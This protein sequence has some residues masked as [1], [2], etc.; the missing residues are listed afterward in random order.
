MNF[1]KHHFKFLIMIILMI[2]FSDSKAQMFWNQTCQF[3]GTNTS[4][5]SLPSTSGTDITGSFTAE[6]WVNCSN[7]SGSERGIISKGSALGVS[8]RYA[9]RINNIGR[10]TV[11][12]NGVLR[13]TSATSVTV[14]TWTHIAA[15]YSSLNDSFAVYINGVKNIATV[16]GGATP[17]TNTDSLYIGI[18]GSGINYIGQLDDVRLWNRSLYPGEIAQNF[19][20]TLGTSGGMYGNLVFSLPFQK[21]HSG[22]TTFSTVDWTGNGNNG[23]GRNVTAV[24]QTGTQYTTISPNESLN[25]LGV[26]EYAA[27]PSNSLVSPSSQITLEAWIYPKS[28]LNNPTIIS[29]NSTTSY[30]LNLNTTGKVEFYPK[31][32]LSLITSKAIIFQNRWTHIAA[33]YNGSITSIYINGTLDT[34]FSAISGAIGTNSDSLFIGCDYTGT[35]NKYFTGYIDEVRIANYAKTSDQIN[36]FMYR[37][38]DSVNQPNAASVNVSYNLDGTSVDNADGG[39][40]L[41]MRNNTLFTNVGGTANQPVSP[42]LRDDSRNFSEGYN[43]R[44]SNKRV[45]LATG[46]GDAFDTLDIPYNVNINDINIFLAINHTDETNLDVTLIAPN[47]ESAILSTDGVTAGGNDN[48]ITI[49]DD[50]ATN[51][52]TNTTYTSF[53]PTVKAETNLFNVFGGDYSQG[54]WILKVTDDGGTADTGRINAWG[55]QFNTSPFSNRISS[56]NLTSLIQGFWNGTSMIPDTVRIY[57]RNT[58]APYLITDSSKVYL[59]ST[60]NLNVSFINTGT[61]TK[62]INLKHRNSIETWS[63]SGVAFKLDSSVTYDFTTAANKAY[64]NNQVLKD[65]KYC[66]YNGNVNGDLFIDLTDVLQVYNAG[67]VFTVGYV[68]TDLTGDNFVDLTD[69][70]LAYNNASNFVTRITPP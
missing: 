8:M 26:K 10:I 17:S 41:F 35:T 7:V 42:M 47:G 63:A 69:V 62:Y 22:G 4:Y 43:M 36:T 19:R 49:F 13:L 45:P 55:I 29:K 14:N 54:K 51:L 58:T 15:T 32:N 70:L 66:M 25:C 50:Q 33:T 56:L 23:S 18:A 52:V 3:A 57:L 39:P 28:Y 30:R 37:S 12:T 48:L 65:G 38:I 9:V 31:D 16:V 20:T 61:A 64:G 6:A 40:R 67:N 46:T 21:N 24:S 68:L 59:G 2:I 53:A 5:I 27:G 60:G 44:I 11:Y 1:S 34:S